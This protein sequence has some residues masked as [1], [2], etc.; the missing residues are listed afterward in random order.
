MLCPPSQV[1]CSD[2]KWFYSPPPI[3]K[4]RLQVW[5]DIFTPL[6]VPKKE[7]VQIWDDTFHLP[8]TT[9]DVISTIKTFGTFLW[10]SATMSCITVSG[11]PIKR[12]NA[13]SNWYAVGCPDRQYALIT[14]GVGFHLSLSQAF[15]TVFL[16]KKFWCTGIAVVNLAFN[17]VDILLRPL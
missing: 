13:T 8:A 2:A 5:V 15:D 11:K 17:S 7:T 3:K 14:K 16:F 6:T 1:K 12:H 10:W 4:K 9:P